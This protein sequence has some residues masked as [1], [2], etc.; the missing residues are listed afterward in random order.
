MKTLYLECKMGAAGDMLGA[1]FLDLMEDPDAVVMELNNIGIKGVEYKLDDAVKCGIR[2]KHLR[3]LVNGLEE[4]PSDHYDSAGHS[5]ENDHED[6]HVHSHEHADDHVHSHEH[7][8]A[9]DHGD[10][11]AH[12]HRTLYEIEDIIESMSV[13][14]EI[15]SDIREIYQ[16][17][18]EAESEAHGVAVDKIHFH[19][20]GNMD[21]IA[22]I[23]ATCYLMHK[24]E[25]DKVVVSPVNVGGGM[26]KTAHGVLPVPA[27]ATAFLLKGIPSYESEVVKSELCTPTGAALIKYFADEFKTQPLMAVEKI[28]Y[29]AGNKDFPQANVVRAVLGETDDESDYVLEFACNIDD[30]TAEEIGFA[31]ERLFE[32]GALEVYTVAADMKKNRPGTVLYCICKQDIREL[33]VQQIFKYTTTIGIREN[34]CNRYV[35]TREVKKIDTPYG[36]VR[37]K[38]SYGY[39]V[40][41]SKLEYDDLAGIAKRTGK[42][43]I[44]LKK[45][46][47]Q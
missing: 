31:T 2:G 40:T 12:S 35:L 32:A 9:D 19:E 38:I 13:E 17:L 4:L 45:E 33:I 43:I 46:I 26:V 27:P 8:H 11:H 18:A 22:D 41:R 25:P 10:G 21:A 34:V 5:H 39:N 44:D 7:E 37:K 42:S 20:V 3:V 23:A 6:G 28:G 29:G 15:K 1:A 14:K 16:L 30:M 36:E 47:D 24:L